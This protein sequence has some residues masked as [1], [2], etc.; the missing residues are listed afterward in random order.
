MQFRNRLLK[1][2]KDAQSPQDSD[3]IALRCIKEDMLCWEANIKGS[4]DTPYDGASFLVKLNVPRDYPLAP[5]AAAFVSRIFHPNVHFST[6]EICLDILKTEWTPAWTLMSVCRAIHSLLVHPE[7]SSPLNCD[8]GNLLR[9]GDT[10]AFDS[11][12]RY[13]AVEL[14]GA[15]IED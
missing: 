8:A 11:V 1:E 15:S 4:P 12:A 3:S 7:A 10:I 13:Y 6:G 5:P 2:I 9:S 14:A